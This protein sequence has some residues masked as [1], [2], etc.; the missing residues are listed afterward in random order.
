M[1]SLIS[2]KSI[3]KKEKEVSNKEISVAFN[4]R[5]INNYL[6]AKGV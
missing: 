4:A 5:N 6:N 3:Y 1:Q 2:M